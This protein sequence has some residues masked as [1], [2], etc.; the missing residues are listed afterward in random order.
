MA[1]RITGRE[2]NEPTF[3]LLKNIKII[4]KRKFSIIWNNIS[5]DN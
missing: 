5:H 1:P 2:L 4:N 3:L